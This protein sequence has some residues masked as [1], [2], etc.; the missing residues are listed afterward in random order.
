MSRS[1]PAPKQPG[2]E[3]SGTEDARALTPDVLRRILF[4][5]L[6]GA[7]GGILFWLAHMPLPWMLGS[8]L[9]TMVA[10]IF[11]APILPPGRIRP[12]L[13]AVIGVLLG[14]GFTPALMGQLGDWVISLGLLALYLAISGVLAVPF[15]MK[16]GG[17]DRI[18]AFCSGMPGGLMEMVSLGKDLGGDERKIILAHAARIVVTISLISFWFR[19]IE[20]Q[21]VGTAITKGGSPS[22]QDLAILAACGVIGAFVALKL[23]LPAA[24]LVGP[25]LLS[26]AVH[27][28]GIT[29]S[30][31][32]QGL[33]IACQ[34]LMGTIMGCRFLGAG[35]REV[36]HAVS[37]SFGATLMTLLVTLLFALV[38]GAFIGQTTSQIVLA[39]A[40]G[41][42]TEMSL[43]ALAMKAEVAYVASHHITRIVLLI[44]FAPLVLSL[45][46]RRPPGRIKPRD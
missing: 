26:A 17:F 43:I 23:R 8:M 14:S 40:P 39:Y 2:P 18:T 29:T 41:G 15:Y 36:I 44:S 19:I 30:A 27:V 9:F 32:P 46:D 25:M 6:L 1:D 35:R 16:V 33:V 34:V 31:P 13:V 37:L 7:A 10:S 3:T 20:G 5:S 12:A 28:T 22:W 11:G 38:F 4:G 24:T 42:L 21:N 45:I